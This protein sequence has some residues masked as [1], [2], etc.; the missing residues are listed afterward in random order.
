MGINHAVQI[1]ES[2]DGLYICIFSSKAC[3][4]FALGFP[5]I[6]F[7]IA[8]SVAFVCIVDASIVV[9]AKNDAAKHNVGS[10]CVGGEQRIGCY[11]K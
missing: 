6:A 4:A 7:L 5:I 10:S 9:E 8:R 11:S 2:A 3:A 1:S